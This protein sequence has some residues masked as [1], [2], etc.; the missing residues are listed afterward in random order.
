MSVTRRKTAT[1][2]AVTGKLESAV[3]TRGCAHSTLDGCAMGAELHLASSATDLSSKS[4][5]CPL[6]PVL[7]S[8][9]HGWACL[10]G[11]R[12]RRRVSRVARQS[13]SVEIRVV[14]RSRP[15]LGPG[16]GQRSRSR[17]MSR[18]HQQPS[19]ADLHYRTVSC[20]II[21]IYIFGFHYKSYTLKAVK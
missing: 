5:S 7:P 9:T 21:C 14:D 12:T 20:I 6:W 8:M 15:A 19:C 2:E 1:G 16:E 10:R 3:P 18:P 17:L 13:S 11:R 4:G